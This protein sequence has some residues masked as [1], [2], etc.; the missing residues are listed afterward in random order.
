MSGSIRRRGAHSWELK[1]ELGKRDPFTSKRRRH[2]SSFKGT[3]R[4]AQTELTRL[5][6]QS[7]GY[8]DIAA[9][10]HNHNADRATIIARKWLSFEKDSV[11]P[12]CFL[13]RHYD[14]RG[15]LLYVGMTMF[16]LARQMQHLAASVWANNVFQTLV[17]PFTSRDELITAEMV[18][19]KSEFPRFNQVNNGRTLAQG[20]V[21]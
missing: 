16:V 10:K 20:E 8:V 9:A 6:A 21:R 18:A 13:Y 5:I 14:A 3:K 12:T 11:A 17:E 4:E 19:I 1:F 2:I 7:K 15:D